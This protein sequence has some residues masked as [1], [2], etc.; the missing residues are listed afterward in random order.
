MNLNQELT[1]APDSSL[2]PT[3]PVWYPARMRLP[4]GLRMGLAGVCWAAGTL[5]M[6]TACADPETSEPAPEVAILDPSGVHY[7]K[8]YAGWAGSWTEWWY[9]TPISDCDQQPSIDPTGEFCGLGNDHP[10]VF[11]LAGNFGGTR[12]S[13]SCVVPEGKALFFPIINKFADNGG[14][15]VPLSDE[16]NRMLAEDYADDFIV[17]EL[18]VEVA[19]VAADGLAELLVVAAPYSGTVP[20]EPNLYTCLGAPDVTGT[21]PGYVTG[22]WVMLPPLEPGTHRI[23]FAGKSQEGDGVFELDVTFDPLVVQ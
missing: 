8:D 22:Y 20:P 3:R 4:V 11:F 2:S 9:E 13:D 15:P 23:R 17:S 19:G 12:I 10:D 16:E 1:Q 5:V 14:V 7:G 21:Y 18:A 6:L